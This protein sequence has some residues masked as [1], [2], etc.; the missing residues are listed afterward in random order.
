MSRPRKGEMAHIEESTVVAA[1]IE[2]VFQLVADHRRARTWMEGFDRFDHISG[3]ERG[4]GARVRAEGRFMGVP[5]R[6]DL[7]IVEYVSPE[8][9]VSQ[10]T[11][12][13]RS[14]TVWT[15]TAV[16]G[17]TKVSF[18]GDYHLPLGLRLI[19]DRAL[20]QFVGDQTR[21]SLANLKRLC[22]HGAPAG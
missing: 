4:V 21:R 7:E 9:L 1:P 20:E 11:T 18:T 14:R 2:D 5:V 22:E 8:R 6:S 12:G 16:D 3:P 17:Q 13:I 15:L 10:S 19:G